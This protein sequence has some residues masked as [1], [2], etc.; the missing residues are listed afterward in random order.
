M[1]DMAPTWLAKERHFVVW[2]MVLFGPH[3]HGQNI[4]FSRGFK[5]DYVCKY[6]PH[7]R[8]FYRPIQVKKLV[9]FRC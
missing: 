4:L 6:F 8:S 7:R 3:M 1:M 5:V 2:P 9:E